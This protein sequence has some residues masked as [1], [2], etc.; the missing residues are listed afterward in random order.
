MNK[1]KFLIIVVFFIQA[2]T[3]IGQVTLPKLI[4]DGMVLQRDVKLPIWGWASPNEKIVVSFN[5][6]TYRTKA[7]LEGNWSIKLPKMKAGGPYTIKISGKNKVEVKDVLIGDVWLCSG[8]SNMEHQLF[9]HD[10]IYANEIAN[11]NYP[12]IRHFKIPRT[13]SISGP[14]KDLVG[15]EWLKAVGEEVRPFSVVTYFFAK[16]IYEKFHIPIGLVNSSIGGTPIE[17]WIPKEGYKNFPD[18]LKIIEENKD[19]AFVNSLKRKPSN[20]TSAPK[21]LDKGLAGEKPWYDISFT[22]KKWRTINIPGYW[23]DQGVKDLNGIVWYRREI[24]IPQSMVGKEARVFLGR[25]V[26]ADELY[27]NGEKVGNTTYQYPQRRYTLPASTLKLG[28][29]IFVIRVTNKSG[30]GGFVPDKP[31]YVFT[32]N[33]TIDLKGYW[34]YK[35]G[36][37]FHPRSKSSSSKKDVKKQRTIRPQREPNSLYNAM[38]APFIQYPIKGT[39][40]YQGESNAGQPEKYKGYTHALISGLREVFNNPE[41]PFIYAQLPNFM[42]VSYSPRESGWAEFR[43]AQFQA[44]SYP[45]TAMTVNIDLGEWNDI[46]PDNKKDV[47]ERMALAGLKLAYNQDIVYSG[48]LYKGYEIEGDKM[49]ISFE[50][51]GS[52]LIAIDGEVLSEF[53][54]AGKDKNFVWAD[55]K[56]EGDKVI[57][58]SEEVPNPKYVRYA[59]ADNPDNPN[60]FNKEGLPASPFQTE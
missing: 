59:W 50:H 28:K 41:M 30:K 11:A 36:K 34:K 53:A 54:I 12:E 39:I 21:K 15:G 27:I 4:S 46:H 9:R 24:D 7:S 52:G 40:W 25:I 10:N 49:I 6:R 5:R 16:K 56:I 47:G 51:L 45:N 38:I 43:N 3:V 14:T 29:N 58:S 31:Y 17:A 13:N 20:N 60:L 57:V 37:V 44:L 23:E 1:L 33:D 18:M 48:P 22:P 42:D 2:N 35:V 19:T 26:D 32:E 8:Q 55:A